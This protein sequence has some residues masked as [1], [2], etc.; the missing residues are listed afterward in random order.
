MASWR[1]SKYIETKL[2]YTCFHLILSFFQKIKSGLELASLPHFSHNVW[3]KYFLLLYS[4]NWPNFIVWLPLLYEIFDNMCIAIVCKPGCDVKNFEIKPIFLIKPFFLHDQKVVTKTKR[5]RK[6]PLTILTGK[7]CFIQYS[8]RM[9][10]WLLLTFFIYL[11]NQ[12]SSFIHYITRIKS[13][14]VWKMLSH[15]Q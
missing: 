14:D 8:T 9:A 3:R 11:H 4:F 6:E 13:T 7:N 10:G 5:E 2:Q 12:L 15:R 1:L